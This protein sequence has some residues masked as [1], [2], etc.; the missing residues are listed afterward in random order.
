MFDTLRKWQ[1]EAEE[2]EQYD[3]G[4]RDGE[5]SLRREELKEHY[6]AGYA[7]GHRDLDDEDDD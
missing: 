2:T 5:R 1:E 6:D 4:V 7:S 3:R